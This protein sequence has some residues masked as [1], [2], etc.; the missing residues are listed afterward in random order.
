[1]KPNI[2]EVESHLTRYLPRPFQ[3]SVHASIVRKCT[4]HSAFRSGEKQNVRRMSRTK[5]NFQMVCL[6]FD[7]RCLRIIGV[8]S[9]DRYPQDTPAYFPRRWSCF[10]RISVLLQC[11]SPKKRY[12]V[13]LT[14]RSCVKFTSLVCHII[15]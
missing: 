11:V 13:K 12:R 6:V 2:S 4:A 9:Y 15:L 5:N 10:N 8:S 14:R 3:D 7:R 1:M